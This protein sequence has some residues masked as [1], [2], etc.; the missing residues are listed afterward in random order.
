MS[1]PRADRTQ[2]RHAPL[3]ADRSDNIVQRRR[4]LIHAVSVEPLPCAPVTATHVF[5]L[6]RSQQQANVGRCWVLLL[7]ERFSSPAA[8]GHRPVP[9]SRP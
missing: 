7:P 4:R 3:K 9:P 5:F 1:M 2:R 8:S 6:R